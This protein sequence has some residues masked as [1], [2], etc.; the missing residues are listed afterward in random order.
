MR[1]SDPTDG[2]RSSFYLQTAG[3][4]RIPAAG[5]SNPNLILVEWSSTAGR[6]LLANGDGAQVRASC[7]QPRGP[8]RT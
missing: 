2:V 5:D 8:I 3:E 1:V 7:Q 6:L 4:N